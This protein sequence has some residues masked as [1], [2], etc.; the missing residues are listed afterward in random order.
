MEHLES[1]ADELSKYMRKQSD[2]NLEEGEIDDLEEVFYV[3][4]DALD[5]IIREDLE[6]KIEQLEKLLKEHRHTEDGK[7]VKEVK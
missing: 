6:E 2:K 4:S 7:V 3:F 1:A 5:G